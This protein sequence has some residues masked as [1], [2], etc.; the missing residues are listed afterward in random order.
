MND[1]RQ[2]LKNQI[3]WSRELKAFVEADESY[4]AP[5]GL[6]DTQDCGSSGF[7]RQIG[8]GTVG[9]KE[10]QTASSCSPSPTRNSRRPRRQPL[11]R[12]CSPFR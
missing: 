10:T 11:D 7:P 8:P 4:N 1:A 5:N 3:G 12:A 9:G 6:V 2:L